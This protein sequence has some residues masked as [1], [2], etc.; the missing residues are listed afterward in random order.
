MLAQ[1]DDRRLSLFDGSLANNRNA[2]TAH[3]STVLCQSIMADRLFIQINTRVGDKVP[4]S[5]SCI[6]NC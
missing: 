5:F 1:S 4:A 6:K 2:V 3:F